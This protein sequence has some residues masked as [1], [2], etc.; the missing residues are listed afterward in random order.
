MVLR[1]N[2]PDCGKAFTVDESKHVKQ[3]DKE[4]QW[5]GVDACSHCGS[6]ISFQVN[7]GSIRRAVLLDSIPKIYKS[8]SV[9]S[10]LKKISLLPG[11]I[12]EQGEGLQ[13]VEHEGK[14]YYVFYDDDNEVEKWVVGNQLINELNLRIF[15][16]E[17][18]DPKK[19]LDWETYYKSKWTNHLEELKAKA[20]KRKKRIEDLK[21][22]LIKELKEE[23][24]L[25]EEKLAGMDINELNNGIYFSDEKIQE[26]S[27]RQ[28]ELEEISEL[29]K[30]FK[31]Y[32]IYRVASGSPEERIRFGG[33]QYFTRQY[34]HSK[35]LP[36]ID[37][38]LA[39]EIGKGIKTH[40][41][42]AGHDSS[43][44]ELFNDI[45]ETIGLLLTPVEMPDKFPKYDSIID[46]LKEFHPDISS[47]IKK[48]KLS[49]D[50]VAP[51]ASLEG[52]YLIKA[53]LDLTSER[54]DPAVNEISTELED[55]SQKLSVLTESKSRLEKGLPLIKEEFLN[56]RHRLLEI[57]NYLLDPESIPDLKEEIKWLR[58]GDSDFINERIKKLKTL[59]ENLN[60]QSK[61]Y[62]NGMIEKYKLL[63]KE[64]LNA[65]EDLSDKRRHI[66][67][68]VMIENLETIIDK[69][70]A[71]NERINK[72]MLKKELGEVYNDV[73]TEFLLTELDEIVSESNINFISSIN[74]ELKLLAE[75]KVKREVF[76]NLNYKV[77]SSK[78]MGYELVNLKD[79]AE[80]YLF[81][82]N[83]QDSVSINQAVNNL[84]TLIGR[85]ILSA[86]SHDFF[87]FPEG[88]ARVDE[89]GHYLIIKV[90]G[91]DCYLDF[92]K[93]KVEGDNVNLLNNFNSLENLLETYKSKSNHSFKEF[94]KSNRDVIASLKLPYSFKEL[95][96][97]FKKLEKDIH[98]KSFD[99]KS[100]MRYFAAR[101]VEKTRKLGK[102]K[103][104]V[105]ALAEG[106]LAAFVGCPVNLPFL[107][108][109]FYFRYL[110]AKA[111]V[112]SYESDIKDAED[113]ITKGEELQKG[114]SS[115]DSSVQDKVDNY[116]AGVLGVEEQGPGEKGVDEESIFDP[117]DTSHPLHVSNEYVN[118]QEAG[119]DV[120]GDGTVEDSKVKNPFYWDKWDDY[121]DDGNINNSKSHGTGDNWDGNDDE[122]LEALLN[123]NKG[124]EK[125][126]DGQ[127]NLDSYLPL[128]AEWREKLGISRTMTYILLS[129]MG[130]IALYKGAKLLKKYVNKSRHGPLG[131]PGPTGIHGL[132]Q[133][134]PGE[135][136]YIKT[137]FE[138][139]E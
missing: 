57:K 84:R 69:G 65:L 21:P 4:G 139:L 8:P 78:K 137:L 63:L 54:L 124:V 83:K 50:E 26:L 60:K 28:E 91:K 108:K 38:E 40:S 25:L 67:G 6:V 43:I 127:S 22:G 30:Q 92:I 119:Y 82:T 73:L 122:D 14:K 135:P 100:R 29:I 138:V 48:A 136:K 55:I 94:I 27:S 20:A 128:L 125:A 76:E 132:M 53:M 116:E 93:K 11:F 13:L 35:K 66:V 52:D 121:A 33:V 18:E 72:N 12:P 39:S 41:E 37:D 77:H 87:K 34:I 42:E 98:K 81:F 113:D 120:D 109:G 111:Q 3:T 102:Y 86:P 17:G 58:K 23:K 118:E 85:K 71:Y 130:M 133:T 101:Y 129:V 1:Y 105:F 114:Y 44:K 110:D 95:K 24:A 117:N 90:S 89:P 126:S 106:A 115:T 47:R 31:N 59:R 68:K 49:L 70:Y 79:Y 7:A 56:N 96:K 62:L 97:E 51:D 104:I 103:N 75:H 99:L 80:V 2:C 74:K 15:N 61:E 64:D 112:L 5:F 46:Y 131:P 45:S 134:V 36:K 32:I 107:G 9:R 88:D 10:G 16:D 19:W 123:Y